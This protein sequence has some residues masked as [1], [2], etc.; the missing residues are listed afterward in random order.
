MQ[1]IN[2]KTHV[3][4]YLT[5]WD[6]VIYKNKKGDRYSIKEFKDLTGMNFDTFYEDVIIKK[7]ETSKNTE[8]NKLE[9]ILIGLILEPTNS[10]SVL[11]SKLSMLKTNVQHMSGIKI[12]ELLVKNNLAK[13]KTRKTTITYQKKEVRNALSLYILESNKTTII[14]EIPQLL[15]Q[16]VITDI[17]KV[18]PTIIYAVE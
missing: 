10:L 13:Y 1:S 2:Y 3:L 18:D 8:E 4:Y 5:E 11:K 17:L 14:A 15:I 9:K 12:A 6:G 16:L 7:T